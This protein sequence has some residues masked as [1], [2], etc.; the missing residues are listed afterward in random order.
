MRDAY[1]TGG[2][3][4]SALVSTSLGGRPTVVSAVPSHL[5]TGGK[6]GGL[7]L[8]AKWADNLVSPLP[9]SLFHHIHMYYTATLPGVFGGQLSSVNMTPRCCSTIPLIKN[10][11]W[12]CAFEVLIMIPSYT[13]HVWPRCC[14]RGMW[15][16]MCLIFVV[17]RCAMCGRL[18]GLVWYLINRLLTVKLFLFDCRRLN[19]CVVLSLCVAFVN[20]MPWNVSQWSYVCVCRVSCLC[21]RVCVCVHVCVL[22]I[23][24]SHLCSWLSWRICQCTGTRMLLWR[25]LSINK[26][27]RYIKRE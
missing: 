23:N 7:N 2:Q 26:S 6:R 12:W 15:C 3:C 8:I 5:C 22:L 18:W 11:H 9:L 16:V 14:E 17:Q 24:L 25:Q 1:L 4:A 19:V 21:V 27:G 10:V 13:Y 20:N